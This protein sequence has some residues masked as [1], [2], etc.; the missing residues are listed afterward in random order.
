MCSST[1]M[2]VAVLVVVVMDDFVAWLNTETEKRDWSLQQV[3]QRIGVSRITI[4]RI[5]KGQIGPSADFCR[6]VALIFGV[7]PEEVFCRAGLLPPGLSSDL[8]SETKELSVLQKITNLFDQ[9]L[10]GQRDILL[11]FGRALLIEE[12]ERQRSWET[13]PFT[14]P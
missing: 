1:A 11:A 13:D 4:T 5:A 6:R 7:S 2:L 12:Q 9:L 3:A 14:S 10:P 8:S